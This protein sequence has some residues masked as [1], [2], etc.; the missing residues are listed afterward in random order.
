MRFIS[1]LRVLAAV[2]RRLSRVRTIDAS[3]CAPRGSHGQSR[4]AVRI[5]LA[6]RPQ[7]SFRVPSTRLP[8]R[9]L[10]LGAGLA[11]VTT[12]WYL[13]QA[14]SEVT[15]VDRQAGAGLETSFA[16]GGQI[17]VSHPEPWANPAAPM[18]VL[19]WLGREDAPLLVRPR[20]DPDLWRWA[21]AFAV[22][23]LP[24]RAERN[25]RAIASLARH[26]RLCLRALRESL[27]LQYDQRTD[28]IL[29][30]LRTPQEWAEAGRRQAALGWLGITTERLD[31]AGSVEREPALADDP[32]PLEGA[33]LAADDESGDAHKF[34]QALADRARQGG[35]SFRFGREV[36]SLERSG[37]R[38]TG[39]LVRSADGALERLA[40]DAVVLCLGSFSPRLAPAGERLGIYPVKGYSV[41]VPII[42]PARAPRCSLTE[43]SRRIVCSRLGEQMR[44]AGT[45]E[46]N[47]FD[48]SPNPLRSSS[49]LDWLDR[50]FPGVCD[51]QAATHWCGLR[52]ATPSNIPHIG[53]SR[54]AG[55]WLNTGHGTLG[56]TLACGSAESL[57]RLMSG[58]MPEVNFP[59]RR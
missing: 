16:N 41:T 31:R 10:V 52:P 40:A 39:A 37:Q 38:V 49:L 1:D 33:L 14:G 6:S 30:L 34:V 56:W 15:V 36:L 35:A 25:T 17:S 47:G 26:S 43:E 51:R 7:R 4:A 28:G 2:E 5:R 22:E 46:L 18:T 27:D 23:C 48:L 13:A 57:V 3:T 11:G 9:V 55:L 20:L 42:D 24:H 29:H 45:A 21:L 12:A 53:A 59:F 44:V 32:D 50:H 19:K 58:G 54:S 8:H